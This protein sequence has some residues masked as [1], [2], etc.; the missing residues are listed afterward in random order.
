MRR[1]GWLIAL[2]AALFL[3]VVWGLSV[4]S[5]GLGPQQLWEIVRGS[6]PPWQEKV[7]WMARMP[8]VIM[9]VIVGAGLSVSGL[10]FQALLKNPLAD[11]Y[12]L[13][14]SGGAAL[15]ATLW[16]TLGA[17]VGGLAMMSAPVGA[18][19][20]AIL[21]LG[22]LWVIQRAS[23]AR[24][25]DPL[26]LLLSGV[27]FN[28]FASAMITFIKAI[29]TATKAQELLFYL[30]GSL[31]VEGLSWTTIG[32]CGLI[33]GVGVLALLPVTQ[34][35]NVLTLGDEEALALGVDVGRLRGWVVGWASIIV[36]MCVAFTGLI[37]FVGLVVPH[38]LR[39]V[40]GPDHRVL[41]PASALLGG[42]FVVGCDGI[43]RQSF[44]VF[45]TTLPVGVITAAVGAPMFVFFLIRSLR[46]RGARDDH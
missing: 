15:G 27:V 35:L 44:D 6:A 43:A 14:V 7:L 36:A 25:L 20:G 12:V 45:S 28:A 13:G 9:G 34:A 3:S 2:S 26:V 11:P 39:L 16:M 18:L 41:L 40:L 19:M 1:W 29:I 37:G 32:A 8:R 5:S 24:A 38:G 46:E 31:A 10:C 21:S 17:S 23:G 42:A 30:M 33:V 4:G 22:V